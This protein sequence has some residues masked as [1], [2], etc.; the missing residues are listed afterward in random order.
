MRFRNRARRLTTTARTI[1]KGAMI[2]A[3]ALR[4]SGVTKESS[5]SN[6]VVGK[7]CFSLILCGWSAEHFVKVL[8][9]EQRVNNFFAG[10]GTGRR[11]RRKKHR[12]PIE[13]RGWTSHR[14]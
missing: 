11:D 12:T 5:R 3:T 13:A 10:E 6:N 14:H 9:H 1:N 8:G 2:E 4:V 7:L